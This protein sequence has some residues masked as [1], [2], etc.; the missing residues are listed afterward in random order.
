M[1]VPRVPLLV[2]PSSSKL[3]GRHQGHEHPPS[4]TLSAAVSQTANSFLQATVEIQ[5]SG[6]VGGVD[7][8]VGDLS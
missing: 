2:T 7:I 8:F 3:H 6:F 4:H 5:V 1:T